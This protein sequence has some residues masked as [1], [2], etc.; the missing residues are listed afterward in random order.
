MDEHNHTPRFT[1]KSWTP[2]EDILLIKA[3][4]KH[5]INNWYKVAEDVPRRSFKQC[6]ERYQI[7]LDPTLKRE[8]FTPDEDAIILEAQRRLGNKWKVI[9]SYLDGRSYNAV[10]NRFSQLKRNELSSLCPVPEIFHPERELPSFDVDTHHFY[11]LFDCD[12][13]SFDYTQ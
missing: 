8:P 1:K 11:S 4:Q 2:E 10:K 9:A 7:K 6:R 3:V 12:D 13:F 5:G